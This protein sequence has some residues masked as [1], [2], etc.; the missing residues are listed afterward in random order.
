[1]CSPALARTTMARRLTHHPERQRTLCGDT[2]KF[3]ELILTCERVIWC[4]TRHLDIMNMALLQTRP[5]DLNKGRFL[6]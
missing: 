4:F 5:G 2:P 3:A 6:V 1:M